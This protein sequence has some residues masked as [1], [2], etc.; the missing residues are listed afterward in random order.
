MCISPDVDARGVRLLRSQDGDKFY[1]WE[2]N[3]QVVNRSA[4]SQRYHSLV[5]IGRRTPKTR[6]TVGLITT[7]GEAL[8]ASQ[9]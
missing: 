6:L 7:R 9:R 8:A 3:G 4:F 1:H 5:S 2:R